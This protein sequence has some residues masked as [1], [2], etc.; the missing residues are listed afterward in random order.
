MTETGLRVA[1][2]GAGLMGRYHADAAVQAGGTLAAVADPRVEQARRVA[3]G[4]VAVASL[5]DLDS[6]VAIDVVHVCAPLAEHAGLAQQAILRGAHLIVEK[7]VAPDAAATA[8]LL[9]AAER[10]GVLL[11][12]VHQFL[13][14]PGVQ[15]VLFDRDRYGALVRCVFEAATAGADLKNLDRDELVAEILPHPLAL[16]ARLSSGELSQ[17]DWV[18]LRPAPGELRALGAVDGTTFEIAISTRGRPTRATLDVVGTAASAHADLYHGYATVERGSLTRTRKVARPFSLAG[19][20]V[21]RAGT[22]LT[23]RVLARE[24]AY[25]GLRELV[26]RTYSAIATGS[27]SPIPEGETLAVAAAR[28]AILAAVETRPEP[29]PE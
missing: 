19:A 28:D 21:G 9:A 7:P 24:V 10:H 13:F 29:P 16:F 22:N 20:T 27:P 1:I 11:V 18:A 8:S 26:R 14:Q 6:R 15:R 23:K 25:P 12:P 4:A 3:R 17:V 5:E 2:V